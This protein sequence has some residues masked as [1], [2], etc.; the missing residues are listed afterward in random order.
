MLLLISVDRKRM[1]AIMLIAPNVAP[2]IIEKKLDSV[3][4]WVEI[5]PPPSII[6]IATPRLA[7]ESIPNIDGP[8]NGL[9]NEVWSSRPAQ[10]RAAPQSSAVIACGRR[11]SSM[12]NR[13]LSRSASPPN[14]MLNACSMGMC[15]EPK[16]RFARNKMAVV[17]L[18]IMVY[19]SPLFFITREVWCSIFVCRLYPILGTIML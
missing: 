4:V 8:A 2:I 10:A 9:L 17:M 13:Q 14:S 12:M 6:T 7:P 11:D 18:S 5:M 19:L 1:I 15:I 16:S 3:N